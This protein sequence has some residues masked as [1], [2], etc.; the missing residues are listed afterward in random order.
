MLYSKELDH[1]L[2]EAR[3]D[4]RIGPSHITLFLAI[5]KYVEEN[6]ENDSVIAFSKE[7]MPLAKISGIATFNKNIRELHSYGYI[8]Y[9]PSYN[10]F[11]GS[12]IL[13]NRN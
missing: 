13:I 7:L 2:R 3:E 11:L 12:R 1:F 4:G 6:G 8:T 5:L 10:H 9:I